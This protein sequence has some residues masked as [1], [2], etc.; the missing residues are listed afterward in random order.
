MF[1]IHRIIKRYGSYRDSSSITVDDISD[2]D[3]LLLEIEGETKDLSKKRLTS[4]LK[5]TCQLGDQITNEMKKCIVSAFNTFKDN[6]TFYKDE[7]AGNGINLS[8]DLR[9]CLN[10]LEESGEFKKKESDLSDTQKEDIKWFNIDILKNFFPQISLQNPNILVIE[11]RCHLPKGTVVSILG[12]SGSGKSTFLNITGLLDTA[13]EIILEYNAKNNNSFNYRDKVTNLQMD[14]LRMNE[15]GF[16]FQSG[17]ILNHLNII[18]NIAFPLHLEGR[19]YKESITMAEEKA[20][21]LHLKER[22]FGNYPDQVSG[23]EYQRTAVARAMIKDPSVIFADEPT[24]NLDPDIGKKVMQ[25]L[26]EWKNSTSTEESHRSLILVTHN[27]DHAYEYSDQIYFLVKGELSSPIDGCCIRDERIGSSG[28][29]DLFTKY[30]NNMLTDADRKYFLNS[31]EIKYER[32][33]DFNNEF[34]FLGCSK[35]QNPP[36]WRWAIKE[37][38]PIRRNTEG[39]FWSS[40][41]TKVQPCSSTIFNMLGLGMLLVAC[42]IIGGVLFGAIDAYN[43]WVTTDPLLTRIVAGSMGGSKYTG[44]IEDDVLEKLRSMHYTGKYYSIDENSVTT[45][46]IDDINILLDLMRFA[47]KNY[48]TVKDLKNH[49]PESIEKP[50]HKEAVMSIVKRHRSPMVMDKQFQLSRADLKNFYGDLKNLAPEYLTRLEAIADTAFNQKEDIEKYLAGLPVGI[51][52][53][54]SQSIRVVGLPLNAEVYPIMFIDIK[55]IKIDEH[56]TGRTVDIK[57]PIL[58]LLKTR[59][60]IE[61]YCE[62]TS[63]SMEGFIVHEDLLDD[64][65]LSRKSKF[66][67]IDYDGIAYKVPI[68]SVVSWLPDNVKYLIT[69]GFWCAYRDNQIVINDYNKVRIG[70]LPADK[71]TVDI[72]KE[73]LSPLF[74]NKNLNA[75]WEDPWKDTNWLRVDSG[76]ERYSEEYWTD[77]L[78]IGS[79]DRQ[80]IKKPQ[81]P[82]NYEISLIDDSKVITNNKIEDPTYYHVSIYLDNLDKI[83]PTIDYVKQEIGLKPDETNIGNLEFVKY[84]KKFGLY[85]LSFIFFSL[86]L[87]TGV[88]VY[89]TFTHRVQQKRKEIGIMMAFGLSKHLLQKIY[90]LQAL[91]IWFGALCIGILAIPF[92]VYIG[93]KVKDVF[94]PPEIQEILI[95]KEYHVQ[96]ISQILLDNKFPGL[97]DWIVSVELF[98]RTSLFTIAGKLYWFN[99]DFIVILVLLTLILCYASTRLGIFKILKET[100]ADLVR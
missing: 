56:I 13:N 64:L 3:S 10:D 34:G 80:L 88:N 52:Q 28:L 48:P 39:G 72:L 38:F 91:L 4:K 20:K 98:I 60:I 50:T 47:K 83:R 82:W 5:I 87:L 95:P 81:I 37:L 36:K 1:H 40:F 46:P 53:N 54:I 76:L 86:A 96:W 70:P 2:W 14:T 18:E 26:I 43:Q 25:D 12:H 31:A 9:K 89:I 77:D 97:A 32:K 73:K 66:L 71:R 45:L 44:V 99:G 92:G 8:P 33:N 75:K 67:K 74:K 51:R 57:D 17:H 90:S 55:F 49:F 93:W 100:P 15:F 30:R 63:N 29:Y 24:G 16:I 21:S 69:E 35:I 85:I 61:N 79:I 6:I 84:I 62:L 42:L 19:D 58:E 41:K 78:F 27:F 22:I 65:N 11:K 59:Y 23:G 94:F 7:I 68:L